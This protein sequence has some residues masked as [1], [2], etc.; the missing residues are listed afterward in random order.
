M[1]KTIGILGTAYTIESSEEINTDLFIK[2][3]DG[4]TDFTDKVI[5]IKYPLN[6]LLND[7]NINHKQMY[8]N[9]VLRHELV[10]AFF[11]EAGL[12]DYAYD[13]T[14]VDFIALQFPKLS[15]LFKNKG[16]EK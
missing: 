10:H 11:H 6:M 12:D 14:L 9:Q 5:R 8:Y 7:E 3:L 15:R 2:S 4:E 1:K 13:E 16:V